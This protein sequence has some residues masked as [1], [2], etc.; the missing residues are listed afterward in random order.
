MK[1]ERVPRG[2]RSF[3]RLEGQTRGGI[4][5]LKKANFQPLFAKAKKPVFF[6]KW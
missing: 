3:L 2:A 5:Y 1:K 6:K 4:I